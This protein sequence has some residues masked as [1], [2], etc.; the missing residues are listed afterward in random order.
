MTIDLAAIVLIVLAALSGAATGALRQ[1]VSLAAAVLGVLAARVWSA[2]VGAGLAREITPV[3]RHLAPLLLF[4]GIFALASL[5][6]RLILGAT[7]L[8]RVVRGPADRG[9]GALLGG[10]KG[11]LAA[12]ALLSVLAL[13]GDHAPDA[14]LRRARG[15]DFAALAREHNLIRTL[16]PGAA[17][18]VERAIDAARRVERAG[19]LARDPESARLL[20]D[21]RIRALEERERGAPLDP[22][23]AARVMEDPQL[24]ALAERLAGRPSSPAAA[25]PSPPPP[26][27]SPPRAAP[28][29]KK[30]HSKKGATHPKKAPAGSSN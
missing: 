3:A 27:A 30:T 9:L 20:A 15:S 14:V 29:P 19:K 7:G 4:L 16:D 2:D 6:G 25:E 11:A 5:A 22:A 23:L 8:A 28:H 18:T 13:A 17:R 26:A 21:P 24:R 1:L 12:W 10:A